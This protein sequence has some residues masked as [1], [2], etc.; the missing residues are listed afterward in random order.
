VTFKYVRVCI[1][2]NSLVEHVAVTMYSTSIVDKEIDPCFLLNHAT[3]ESPKKN[4]PP[5]VLFHSSRQFS[6]L[7][8]EY[9]VN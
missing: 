6:Q 5:L 4:A 9:A 7:A 1:I 8:Y 2:H 3:R